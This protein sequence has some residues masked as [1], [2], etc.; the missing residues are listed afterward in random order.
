VQLLP[1]FVDVTVPGVRITRSEILAVLFAA[2]LGE[3][4]VSPGA[5]VSQR[6][7]PGAPVVPVE[8]PVID[9][10]FALAERLMQP[11]PEPPL[12]VA[13]VDGSAKARPLARNQVAMKATDIAASRNAIRSLDPSE[14]PTTFSLVLINPHLLVR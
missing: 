11:G 9:V 3:V 1:Q 12:S 13:V 14:G 2:E 7:V 4:N 5:P 10:V 6:A 8:L